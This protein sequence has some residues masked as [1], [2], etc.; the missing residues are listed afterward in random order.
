MRTSAGLGNPPAKYTTNGNECLNNIA[1]AHADYRRCSWTEFNN[2]MYELV[3]LQSKEVEKAV[4]GMGEYKFCSKYDFLQIDSTRWFL[5]TGEQRQKHLKAVFD[6]SV[7]HPSAIR[8]EGAGT[9]CCLSVPVENTE[10]TTIPADVL[11][12][13]WSKA[14]RI[15]QTPNS[16]CDAPGMSNAKMNLEV[17]HTLSLPTREVPCVVM[18]FVSG[19]SPTNLL[20]C[21]G[22]S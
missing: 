15:L 12:N 8:Q 18:M 14:E 22:C 20:S 19:G 4:Y 1:Q 21:C 6:M 17:S 9:S 7:S 16:I 5:K 13:I 10:I 11:S 3:T 2:N